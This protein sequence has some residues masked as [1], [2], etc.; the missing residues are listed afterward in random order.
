MTQLLKS[1]NCDG[2]NGL[3]LLAGA[4]FVM[5]LAVPAG[6]MREHFA[7]ARGPLQHGEAWRL[8]TGHLVHLD[9]SHALLNVVGLALVWALYRGAWRLGEWSVVLVTGMLA[10]D[11][12]LWWLQPQ[13]QW[14]V[15]ASGVLHALIAA[16][17][18][19]QWNTERGIC[20]VVAVLLGAKLLWEA[21][22]GALPFAGESHDVV[23]SAHRYGAAGGILAATALTLRRKWL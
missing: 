9:L 4:A 19:A 20:I 3:S 6:Y 7:Y 12:G 16:G 5:L 21:W 2:R 15:G 14:Y 1:L 13:V 23:L 8:V 10:I 17:V 22:H 11:A 18:I